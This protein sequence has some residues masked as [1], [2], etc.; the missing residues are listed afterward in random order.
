MQEFSEDMSK[1]TQ[2]KNKYNSENYDSLRIVVPKGRK[3]TVE[4]YAKERGDSINNLVNTLLRNELGI[5]EAEWKRGD[6]SD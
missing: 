4:A 2:Y 1:Y 3:Q 5:S 6:K